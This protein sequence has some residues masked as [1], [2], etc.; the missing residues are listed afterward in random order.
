MAVDFW[1][2]DPEHEA[3]ERTR[4]LTNAMERALMYLDTIDAYIESP[5]GRQWYDLAY[6]TLH[7]ALADEKEQA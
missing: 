3:L 5:L 6:A 1:R 7:G 2:N 4:K